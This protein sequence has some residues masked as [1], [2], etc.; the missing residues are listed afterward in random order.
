M[1]IFS[2]KP[3]SDGKITS[4]EI[5]QLT[6]IC[7]QV[8]AGSDANSLAEFSNDPKLQKLADAIRAISQ[9]KP[10]Q[11]DA[12]EGLTS[13][14]NVLGRVMKGDLEARI[15]DLDRETEFGKIAAG[16]NNFLNVV[17]CF[18]SEAGET[19]RAVRDG[20]YYRRILPEGMG[21]EFLRHSRAINDVVIQ[22][23]K[24]DLFV[25]DM[26]NK[27]ITN[28][29]DMISSSSDLAPKATAMADTASHTK[30]YC[31]HAVSSANETQSSVQT[32]ASAA[33]ELSSSISEI[34]AQVERSSGLIEETVSDVGDTSKAISE[35]ST[36]V[37]RITSILNI[38]TEISGQTNLL[39]L[40]ATIEAARAGEAGKGFA[41]VASEVKSLAQKTAE[42]TDQINSQL[43]K[44]Q[45]V[46][47]AAID[48]VSHI[49]E[50]VDQVKEISQGI[51][52]SMSEQSAATNEISHSAQMAA[53][54]TEEANQRIGEV[55]NGADETGQAAADMLN[56]V[57]VMAEKSA[58]LQN[59]L[60]DFVARIA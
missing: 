57:N 23:Q 3:M 17:Q 29:E 39:A 12:S 28:V 4:N 49:G 54:S 55:N 19:I 20:E 16:I 45:S 15:T 48:T 8:A 14:M 27:F 13:L 26:T 24:K 10:E 58:S 21:G 34:S 30:G 22:I 43:Q 42:A 52:N 38:I 60:N 31:D 51:N 46:T 32:V 7:Q 9:S 5:S 40:N 56:T 50:K 44:I 1:S 2:R 41:V 37:E 25:K 33:E 36:E 35:L 6:S 59:D 11:C 53:T 47:R 18:M